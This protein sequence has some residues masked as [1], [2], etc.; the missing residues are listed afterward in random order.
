MRTGK[1]VHLTALTILAV[2]AATAWSGMAS[3][4]SA[5]PAA[6]GHSPTFAGY[7]SSVAPTKATV[8]FKLP[9]L[10][11][12]STYSGIVPNVT[13]TNFTTGN[14]TSGGVYVQ[15]VNGQPNYAA[16]IEIN[17][18]FSFPTQ[19]MNA[20]DAIKVSLVV[21]STATTVTIAD[22]TT[23]GKVKD[24]VSGPGGGGSFTGMSAGDSAVGSPP[25]PVPQFT[26]LSLSGITVNGTSLGSH[27][28]LFGSDMYSGT[29]LQIKAGKLNLAGTGFVT[30][31]VHT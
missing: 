3:G 26:T 14:F 1:S 8:A 21:S 17:N 15:C 18:R 7:Q 22:V 20:G 13:F 19:T 16:L 25:A 31:F 4:A 2:L 11:C 28:P 12:T 10:T 30:T 5:A 9:A 24:T 23:K 6:N 27:G 29:T